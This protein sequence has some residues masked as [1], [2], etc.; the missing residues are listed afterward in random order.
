[1]L[2]KKS[3]EKTYKKGEFHINYER[4]KKI[5]NRKDYT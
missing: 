5:I 2:E 4:E 3:L 1:M